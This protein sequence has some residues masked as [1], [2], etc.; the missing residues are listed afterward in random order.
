MITE[1]ISQI[2]SLDSILNEEILRVK[3][4]E[5]L[6]K[7]F[8]TTIDYTPYEFDAM[9]FKG[10]SALKNVKS[11]VG[12]LGEGVISKYIILKVSIENDENKLEK[13]FLRGFEA[14]KTRHVQIATSFLSQEIYPIAGAQFN[15]PMEWPMNKID[16]NPEK[17]LI[18]ES[19][20]VNLEILVIGGAMYQFDNKKL[21]IFDRSE[22]FGSVP[23]LYLANQADLFQQLLQK[24]AYQGY[25]FSYK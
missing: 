3:D 19:N 25:K 9:N 13:F 24:P 7:G 1:Y 18:R 12:S 16:G 20:K 5:D 10:I 17:S 6:E 15:L 14:I 11:I 8:D 2:D 22:A 21:I 23:E 4:K